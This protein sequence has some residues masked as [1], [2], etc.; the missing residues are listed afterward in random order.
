MNRHV[1]F[2]VIAALLVGIF[3][4]VPAGAQD[5]SQSSQNQTQDEG[6][7]IIHRI[8]PHGA[9]RTVRA[10]G[11]T[12]ADAPSGRVLTQGSTGV[13]TPNMTYHGG[14][15]ISTPVVYLIWYGNW[16]QTNGADTPAA[17]AVVRDFV[18]SI[19]GSPYYRLNTTASAGGFTITGNVTFGGETTDTGSQGT[20]LTDARV[21]TI[22][23]SAISSGR[24]PFNSSGV[25]FVLTSSN[26]SETSG[27]CS[28]YCGWHTAANTSVGHVRY[29]FVGN[30][31]RCLNAC[32]AQTNSPN[33]IAGADAMVSIVAHELEEAN[34][35]PDLNAWFDANGAENADKCAWTFGHFQ[36]QAPNGSFANMT[37]TSPSG[38]T[39]NYLVQRNIRITS[40]GNFC[41]MDSTH[42]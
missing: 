41:M 25:Y 15:L 23:T 17:Q 2:F 8:N 40:T 24:L 26:V 5:V 6:M 30:A 10:K 4:V 13:A 9:D 29:S 39:R 27:F 11:F 12:A 7:P 34:T 3:L 38:T 16:N 37:L 22:V 33:G 18:R 35:D 28:Q 42:N 20:S 36:F 14:P 21:L 32:S 31:A 19:G 1:K